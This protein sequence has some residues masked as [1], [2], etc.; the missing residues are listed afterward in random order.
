MWRRTPGASLFQLSKA[1]APVRVYPDCADAS[2]A[3]STSGT[4]TVNVG[5]VAARMLVLRVVNV[6]AG[7]PSPTKR[8]S[9]P[10]KLGL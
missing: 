1:A 2:E 9:S 5:S 4:E 6:M 10:D 7:P 3:A 8:S